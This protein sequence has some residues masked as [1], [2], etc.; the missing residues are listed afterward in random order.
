[1]SVQLPF[2][3]PAIT[4]LSTYIAKRIVFPLLVTGAAGLGSA[5]CG[6]DSIAGLSQ[7]AFADEMNANLTGTL[8]DSDGLVEI[9]LLSPLKTEKTREEVEADPDFKTVSETKFPVTEAVYNVCRDELVVLNGFLRVH[10]K[11]EFNNM[12]LKYR[13]RTWQET[14]GIAGSAEVFVD[15]DNN[16]ETPPVAQTV[17]YN[18]HIW[19]VDEFVVDSDALPFESEYKS[20][21]MLHREGNEEEEGALAAEAGAAEVGDDMYVTVT[22]RIRV[23]ENGIQRQSFQFEAECR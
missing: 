7:P 13:V 23:N 19:T 12:T 14:H 1:M 9:P 11:V 22:S 6:A 17:R 21:L 3:P 4:S 16:E 18:N 10:E 20:R 15:D 5:G 8:G 2:E